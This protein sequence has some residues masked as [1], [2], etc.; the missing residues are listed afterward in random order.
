MSMSFTRRIE[1]LENRRY[2]LVQKHISFYENQ[3]NIYAIPQD[4][5][6]I[7]ENT[8]KSFHNDTSF[9]QLVMGP[10]GSGKTTLCLQH[11]VKM[12]SMMPVWANGRRKMRCLVIRN[13]SGEL[14]STTLQSWL[15]WF[16]DLGDIHK[17]QKPI[18]TYE[19]TFN[20][21]DGVIELEMIFLALDREDDL[22]KLKSLEATWAYINELS[23][24]PQG[25]LAHL[26]GRIN[27]RYPSKQ[28]C[29][30]PYPC[31]IIAD[32]NP[33]DE[34]HW[35]YRDFDLKPVEGYKLYKQPPGLLKDNDGKWFQNPDC[36]N[37]RNL[38]PDYYTKLANGQNEQFVKVY[39]L[40]EYG[41]VGFGMKVYPEYNDD[42]HSVEEIEAIQGEPLHLG[43]D[44][45]LTPACIVCQFTARGQL[46]V[47]REYTSSSMG[48][49]TFA[50]SVV[51]PSLAQ[52]FPYCKIGSSQADPSGNA[53]DTI[54]EELSCIGELNS[55]GIKTDAASTNEI[56]PRIASVRYFLNRMVD[57]KP[58][59]ILSRKY[60]P[61]LRKGF[62][63]DY[64]FKRLSIAGEERY[65]D[66]PNKASPSS[67]PHDGLHYIAL[68]FA[69]QSIMKEKGEEKHVNMW[70]P[71]FRF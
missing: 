24:V 65:H 56:A 42:L 31:G 38:A 16:G 43:W 19:H 14:H 44:F 23:E 41:S 52:H 70:N 28:M 54:M 1:A 40:G 61:V 34:D 27:H 30:E 22:R 2:Q 71:G 35:I 11:I 51:I 18:L 37:Y 32:T 49:R 64:C 39:C 36:D 53:H 66:K 69:P 47:L 9:V 7:P 45:G 58:C 29:P 26:I 68:R 67:D 21:G 13:T 20:D 8:A 62:I 46:L 5:I 6:Y 4:K 12:A 59:F 60:A 63:K 17:R 10:Y 55:L 25:A 50:E 48:I 15:S 3:T 33:P 57:G